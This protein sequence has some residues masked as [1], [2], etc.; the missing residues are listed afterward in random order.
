M[1]INVGEPQPGWLTSRALN[2]YMLGLYAAPA[3]LERN[4]TE[5]AVSLGVG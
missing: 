3:Y 4:P 2:E 1:S 5:A